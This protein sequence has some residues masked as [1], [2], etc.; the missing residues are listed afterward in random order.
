MVYY[1]GECCFCRISVKVLRGG[2]FLP[3]RAVRFEPAQ[4]NQEAMQKMKTTN[5]WLMWNGRAWLTRWDVFVYMV[6][7][8][9][10]WFFMAGLL[11][12]APVRFLGGK[13]YGFISLNRRLLSKI[14]KRLSF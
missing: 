11:K 12:K 4:A 7:L 14:L 13:F 10:V 1:D 3:S 5:S 8:S 2:L 9:P 6:S